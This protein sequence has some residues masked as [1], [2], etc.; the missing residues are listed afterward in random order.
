MS[1][2]DKNL[3][4]G[5]QILFSTKKHLIVFFF[6]VLWL[7]FSIY[8]FFY[9][10]TNSILIHLDWAPWFVCFI[11]WGY[12]W[13]EYHFSEFAVSNK[14]VMMR[15]GFF[16]RHAN[17]MRLTAI[18]QININQ[19]LLGQLL[20]YGKVSINSFGIYDVFPLISKPFLF[21]KAINEQVDQAVQSK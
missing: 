14:R 4:P 21:Q 13:L 10:R 3:L 11:L 18:A 16:N 12:V 19:S 17:E 2:F 15:E 7:I 9:M 6:P 8:A 20:N 5:E 1:Y